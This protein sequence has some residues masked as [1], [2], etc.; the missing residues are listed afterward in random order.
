MLRQVCGKL[1]L[2]KIWRMMP[3][4]LPPAQHGTPPPEA[5]A[6]SV[7]LW[8]PPYLQEVNILNILDKSGCGGCIP[9]VDGIFR[10]EGSLQRD[11]DPASGGSGNEMGT[12]ETRYLPAFLV[13]HLLRN[14]LSAVVQAAAFGRAGWL[15]RSLS[16][17][18]CLPPPLPASCAQLLYGYVMPHYEHGSLAQF[19]HRT[20]YR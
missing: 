10:H 7:K 19:L 9:S 11:K 8:I 17:K 6:P 16:C 12:H 14:E 13:L 5:A 3:P 1:N 18:P 2:S 15:T 20:C 4:T